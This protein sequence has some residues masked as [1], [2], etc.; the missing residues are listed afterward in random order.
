MTARGLTSRDRA[1]LQELAVIAAGGGPLPER[2]SRFAGLLGE[3]AGCDLLTLFVAEGSGDGAR[4]AGS[5]PVEHEPALIGRVLP[6][7]SIGLDLAGQL[8]AGA[9]FPTAA[10]AEH[11]AA[12]ALG[13][14]GYGSGWVSPLFERGEPVG[15]LVAGRRSPE[16]P[17]ERECALLREAAALLGAAAAR[18]RE[19]RAA[20]AAAARARAAAE[21]GAALARGDSFETLFASLA[22]LLPEALPVDYTGLVLRGPGGFALV[23]EHP[24]GVHAGRPPT[25]EGNAFIEGLARRGD[26]LQFRPEAGASPDDSLSLAGYGRAAIGVLREGNET[27]GLLLVARRAHRRFDDQELGF[28]GLLRALLSQALTGD[29]RRRQAEADASRAR[30]LNEL[31]AH[32]SVGTPLERVFDDLCAVLPQ[33]LRYDWVALAALE[34]DGEHLRVVGT[35][36]AGRLRAGMTF[37]RATAPSVRLPFDADGIYQYATAEALTEFGRLVAQA[38]YRR[39]LA[40]LL[41]E[42][43]ELVGTLHLARATDEPFDA[44]E[45]AFIATLA[46]LLAVAVGNR[47]RL[48][49]T[50]RAYERSRILN[51]LALLLNRGEGPEA[52]FEALSARLQASVDFDG[53]SL[54]VVDGP[55][56]FRVVDSLRR[57]STGPGY[58]ARRDSFG[59]LVERLRDA[60]VVEATIEEFSGPVAERNRAAGVKRAAAVALRHEGE[61]EGLLLMSRM[62][63]RPLEPEERAHLETVA[64]LL[65]Q[66]M[67]NHR[68]VRE[69][70]GEMVRRQALSELTALLVGG[71]DV[72][73]HFDTLSRILL[74]GVGFDWLSITYRDPVTGEYRPIRSQPLDID[75]EPNFR[76]ASIGE[77]AEAGGIVQYQTRKNPNRVPQALM[78]A[79]YRRAATAVISS[80]EGYEGLLTIGRV[81]NERFDEQ[82]L[83]FIRLVTAL[84]GQAVASH[85]ARLRRERQAQQEHI[86][87]QLALFVNDG[88]PI[89]AHFER[90]SRLL[91]AVEGIDLV[92]IAAR[93]PLGERYR[94]LRSTDRAGAAPAFVDDGRVLRM[95]EAGIRSAQLTAEE[96]ANEP[97]VPAELFEGGIGRIA[98][99]LLEAGDEPEGVL[100]IGRKGTRPFDAD[101]VRFAEL[102]GALV[103]YA[104][105]NRRRVEQS[106]AEAAEQRIIAKAA[107]AAAREREPRAIA[108]ALT[109]AV[110]GFI[111][112]PLVRI[113]FLRGDEMEVVR[114]RGDSVRIPIGPSTARALETGEP[115]VLGPEAPVLYEVSRQ[116]MAQ[117]GIS[118]RIVA[119]A[120]AGGET[121]GLLLVFSRDA[122]FRAGERE[123]RLVRLIADIVGPA[124]ANLQAEERQRREA[125]EQR[126]IAEAAAAVAREVDPYD[127]MRG[128]QQ[129]A[130]AFFPKPFAAFGF[131]RDDHVWFPGGPLGEVRLP[132][133]PAFARARAGET[134]I[135]T[136][137]QGGTPEAA[138]QVR[139]FGLW[140]HVVAPAYSRGDIVGVL[141][142]GTRDETFVPGE[143]E[144][145]LARLIADIVGPAM[146]NAMAVERERREA[147]DQAVVAAA[148]SAV[149]REHDPLAIVHALTS[150]ARRFVPQ[151][152]VA[153][154]FLDGAQVQ[155]PNRAGGATAVQLGPNFRQA[156]DEGVAV[157]PPAEQRTSPGGAL[158]ELEALGI[159][160]H[161]I[162]AATSGGLPVGLLVIG[163]RDGTFAPGEREV[164]LA[165][166]IADIVGPAMANARAAERERLEAEDQ[167]LLAEIAAV[168][169]RE[170]TPDAL[171]VALQRPLRRLVPLPIVSFGLKEGD[172]IHFPLGD[173][174]VF[175][176]EPDAYARTAEETGQTHA[177]RLPADLDPR[178]PLWTMGA[179]AGST[180]AARAGGRTIGFLVVASRDPDYTFGERELR[181]LRL[182]AQIV[183]PAME[184]ARAAQ[185]AR[186]DAEEQRFLADIA[187]VATRA[188][189]EQELVV[190]LGREFRWLVPAARLDLLIFDEAGSLVSSVNPEVRLPVGFDYED[191][192]APEPMVR[193]PAEAV[194]EASRQRQRELGIVRSVNARLASGGVTMGVL[195]LGTSDPEFRF[196]ARH[197]R[198]IKLAAD[199]LG[200]AMA[201]L[202]ERR[203]RIEEAEEQRFLADA[204]A[205]A[206]RATADREFLEGLR[207]TFGRL[208]PR[209]AVGFF[210]IEGEQI[211]DAATGDVWPLG[212]GI[213]RAVE[214]RQSVDA[215]ET[216]D[217]LPEN[218][219]RVSGNG[220]RRWVTTAAA[221]EG[222]TIGAFIV[223]TRDA[224]YQFTERDLRLCRLVAD[225][226]GPAMANFRE[227]RRR[228]EEAEDERIVASVAAAAAAARTVAEVVNFL[229]A[230]LGSRVPGAYAMYGFVRGEAIAYQ[231]TDPEGRRII[232]QDELV[233]RFSPVG[234]EAHTAGQ[235]VGDLAPYRETFYGELGLCAYALT[236][237]HAAGGV[238]GMLMVASRD[239]AFRFGPRE[240]AL[241]RR[242]TAVVG[243]VIDT[244][245]AQ[246][247]RDRQAEEQRVLAEVSAAAATAQGPTAI[248]RGITPALER[249]VP[250]A[251][252]AYGRF[253]GDELAWPHL[254]G[255]ELR[256]PVLPHESEARA[257]GQVVVPGEA[258]PASHYGP[259]F[260]FTTVSYTATYS[261]G[262]ATGLLLVASRE[263]G[264]AF[265]ERDLGL[266]RRIAQVVGPAIEAAIATQE[267]ER[268]AAVYGLI[269]RSLS[270][271]VILSDRTGRPIFANALGQEIVRAI[272]PDKTA[273]DIPAIAARLP[274][275]LREP[276]RRAFED[277]LGARG[278][279]ELAID[280]EVRHFDYEFVPLDDPQMRVL[281]VAADVTEEVRRAAEEAANRARMEQA[282]RLA[283]LGELIGGVAHELNNPLTAILGFAEVLAL[284]DT[285]G[286]M[287]EELAII[288]KEALR[289]RNIVRDLL[290]IAR[291]G[292][293]EH[294][295]V[296]IADVVG[297]VQRLRERL[298]Q[299]A[300]IEVSVEVEPGLLAWGNEH[301]L[302][303]VLL[304]LVTNAE[305]ALEGRPVRQIAIAGS[306]DEAGQVRLAVSDTG[307]GMDEATRARIFEPFFTT[308]QGVGTGLGL[309]L[310][311]SII[312]SHGGSIECL[313]E[314]AIGT[315]FII[316]LPAP[317]GGG[318]A[319]AAAEAPAP[320]RQAT[321]LVID[322]EPS[323][324]KVCRRLVESLGHLCL[325]AENS[326]RALALAA[327]FD[328]DIILCDYRLASETADAVFE[329]L[330]AQMPHLI[331][332]TII[333]TGATTDAGV[334]ALVERYGLEL[335]AKP[336]G[337]E[338][339]ARVI[340]ERVTDADGSAAGEAQAGSS[341]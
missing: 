81:E 27:A 74:Q 290:F 264:H 293:A 131:F 206:A 130:R 223:G 65:G 180:T 209:A 1:V 135:L 127:M 337:V 45:R 170:A 13:R 243:P 212:P 133:G 51:E 25:A 319:D 257:V 221:S 181:L 317:A 174:T 59:G 145:R 325:D 163:S 19:L 297:H 41:Q 294:G 227:R 198:V 288:Q 60:T 208:V 148:A 73:E 246:A 99:V 111:P 159:Q 316:T 154:G 21:L 332:R 105:A 20:N 6:A 146:A 322:D 95:L 271:A 315:S 151:P 248:L 287:G 24:P 121:A 93:D 167:R 280:G 286:Q 143:R 252:A 173:G 199:I 33:A 313:S 328:P 119:P 39:G 152:Y 258:V 307:S 61:D 299:G 12:E 16:L 201:N 321:V 273:N 190:Q 281:T 69:R 155:F 229:P 196:T 241:L 225:I 137:A 17:G 204:A 236:S 269:L 285:T 266:L 112:A 140:A 109:D 77:T 186:E 272:D 76:E 85:R 14:L 71:Q 302:T 141:L 117:S 187:A 309:P 30:A 63:D 62:S 202:R 295:P 245:T 123:A 283:A 31:A 91:L 215:L 244:V 282:S 87:N 262:A 179:Q 308:K 35:Q 334:T 29:A 341:G 183:G 238:S 36:P 175:E 195:W 116:E 108:D 224:A 207:A 125:E 171:V 193:T 42:G 265:S 335:L 128:L 279:A 305:H 120:R 38:G 164:R 303:Q 274:E 118:T 102:A 182:I 251:F 82:E 97:V 132:I 304:N 239:P 79:G 144:A 47:R 126:I 96:A 156:L 92:S 50:T 234:R 188:A 268:Q 15:L 129:T 4:V 172:R 327:E 40:A 122:D 43:Q 220:L 149:A 103:A 254:L 147:E 314:P 230:A 205:A 162:A 213:R 110:A 256:L 240:L 100:T 58:R 275:E 176:T 28:I 289:A 49:D 247:E 300:G 235:G 84:V 5:W 191:A 88:A 323:L 259:N 64:A 158:P 329:G 270:E 98:C 11:P 52:F 320:A 231:V 194:T 7:E 86:L 107:A 157:V 138:E 165:R 80:N 261:A 331:P 210:Y 53:L 83:E 142:L 46:R 26:V 310:S 219:E 296:A 326:E 18:E 3:A 136:G 233:M 168:A 228:L 336:Y 54:W 260:G 276:F 292:T 298:W 89:E 222:E 34:P 242:V 104:I 166:L 153:F 339:I 312:R 10:P 250:R 216:P 249:F 318:D 78:R 203:R 291:P 66:A 8:A 55:D 214:M 57:R 67:A 114:D 267:R 160:A 218:R 301:Q 115:A 192:H 68:K 330:E 48:L 106:A 72:R 37:P 278:R 226:A 277:G 177:D 178:S 2:F 340:R 32:L 255:G 70:V 139:R 184:N 189:T 217:I 75:A 124:L 185:R 200:P 56:H 284:S 161:I 150:V 211:R 324:R 94:L 23:G 22:A 101:E 90:L 311:Y 232:G 9:A 169:A 237:Y 44:R 134:F 263:P 338:D 113:A 253:D 197:L 306:R 333:A